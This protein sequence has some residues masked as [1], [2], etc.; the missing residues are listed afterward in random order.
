MTRPATQTT[1]M[2]KGLVAMTSFCVILAT[3][4]LT[5]PLT[6]LGQIGESLGASGS[7]LNWVVIIGS[8]SGAVGTGLLPP[9]ASLFGQRTMTV[10]TMALLTLGSVI[11]AVA[12]N[13]TILLIGRFIGG[14][15]LGAIALSLA[16]ARANLSG[17]TLGTVL[18]WIAAAEG[19]AAGLGF[20]L[21]GLLTDAVHVSW[22]AVFGI[23]AVLGVIGVFGALA[24]IPRR[25]DPN[26]PRVDWLGGGLLAL[27][28]ALILV[29]LSM[30]S[31][32]GWGSAATL[33]PL[34]GGV[35]VAAIWWA[36]E[37]RVEQPLVNTRA[38][39]NRNFLR[40]WLVFF[41]AG[42]LAWIINFTLPKFTETP[43]G[44]GFGFGYNSLVSGFVMLVFCTGIVVGSASVGRLSRVVAPR[45]I[46]LISF[47]GLAVSLLLIAFLHD[48]AWQLWTWPILSGLSYGLTSASAYL[49]FIT[50][51]RPH[52]VATAAS[53]GQISAP[54]GGAIGSAGISA[55]LTA[56]VI[57]VGGEAVPTEHSFRLGW[58]I[59][60][61]VAVVGFLIV[62][63]LQPKKVTDE[64]PEVA[65]TVAI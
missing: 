24:A 39:R 27:A 11:G 3:L 32:W 49:T 60:V 8:L 26:R 17:K 40:G 10:T 23:L 33:V 53:I 15:T 47:T 50:A 20:V 30:G 13:M 18:A 54:L 41:L 44:A 28:L 55:V 25:T 5:L 29:P 31:K 62:A 2:P 57:K 4:V 63:L 59:G 45:V 64:S 56:Q 37:E 52:E 34:I 14:F 16:I 6:V 9:L 12:P 51:L 61:G 42:M 35:V 7:L 19:I 43:A 46:C 38:L 58:L 1:A 65:E 22:R 21:G 48:H 36:V